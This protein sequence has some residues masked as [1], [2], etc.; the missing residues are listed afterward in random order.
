MGMKQFLKRQ[1]LILNLLLINPC[2]LLLS[3]RH[4]VA[5]LVLH[6][7]VLPLPSLFLVLSLLL[8]WLHLLASL[9][10]LKLNGPL[11]PRK[12]PLLDQERVINLVF[13]HNWWHHP[14]DPHLRRQIGLKAILLI[15]SS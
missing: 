4:P 8:K 5:R 14:L 3:Q 13:S 11:A 15:G 12:K 1:N 6:L 7:R 10:S 9:T 2:K